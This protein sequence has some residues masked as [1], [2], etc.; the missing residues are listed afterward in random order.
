V[1]VRALAVGSLL[2]L[3]TFAR[4]AA[5]R[6]C[7]EESQSYAVGVATCHRF[8]AWSTGPWMSGPELTLGV[9]VHRV[10]LSGRSFA[11]CNG[12]KCGASYDGADGVSWNDLQST[13]TT[14]VLRA[15]L[16]SIGPLR[17]GA[18]V[19]L[20]GGSGADLVRASGATGGSTS[21]LYSTFGLFG[22][23]RVNVGHFV[24]G[25]DAVLGSTDV[26]LE[27]GWLKVRG[28]GSLS[29]TMNDSRL[30]LPVD[31]NVV[32]YVTPGIGIGAR[33]GA[34][35]LHAREDVFGGVLVR[36]PF[37]AYEGTR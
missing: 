1:G 3:L 33:F 37:T 8:G 13:V 14:G 9:N 15:S 28:V 10:D 17:L 25:V 23:G 35:T 19:E 6:G 21:L 27:T 29:T 34:D 31:A 22:G 11:F 16:F 7:H 2:T 18:S 26:S 5:A 20:G 32:Y 36:F 4:S 24:L 30:A 12:R